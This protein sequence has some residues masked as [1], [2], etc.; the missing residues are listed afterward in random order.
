[1]TLRRC[2]CSNPTAAV[3]AVAQFEFALLDV[4][5]PEPLPPASHAVVLY[6]LCGYPNLCFWSTPAAGAA[7]AAQVEFALLDVFDPEPLP[8]SSRLWSHPRV[9]ITPH[10]ASMTTMKVGIAP[11]AAAG[12]VGGSCGIRQLQSCPRFTECEP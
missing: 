10:V 7:A 2:C 6:G 9:R 1:M 12:A 5:D 4:F 11:A 3:A 8:P